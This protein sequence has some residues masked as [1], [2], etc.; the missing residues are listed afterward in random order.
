MRLHWWMA[1]AVVAAACA[2]AAS[3]TFNKD[4][5]PIL[6]K[7]CASCHRPGEVAPFSL[8]TYSDAKRYAPTIAD[9]TSKHIMPP[10]KASPGFGEF[11]D[12][13]A[14]SAEQ[15]ATISAWAKN[16]APEGDTKD[17]PAA[18]KF[19]DGWAL[20]PPDMIVEMPDTYQVP[21]DGY[22]IYKCFVIRTDFPEDT[23]IASVEV[24]PGNRRVLH[25]TVIYTDPAHAARA[26]AGDS[27]SYTCYGGPGITAIQ[28]DLMAGWAPG[29]NVKRMPDG[30]AFVAPKGSDLIVQNHY[31]PSG[32]PESDKTTIGI[33]FQKTP[34]VK[35]IFGI[36]M[37]QPN[38]R[39]PAG[40][41][42]QRVTATFTTPIELELSGIAPHMHLLGREMK[43]TA[44]LPDGDVKPLIWIKDWDFNWQLG[45]EFK[46]SLALPA[47]T[48]FDL[49]AFYDNSA[50]NPKNPSNPPKAVAWGEATTDEMCAAMLICVS[51]RASDRLTS[52]MSLAQQLL[53]GPAGRRFR[54]G[55]PDKNPN[56]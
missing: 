13:R 35:R 54:S 39:I 56:H 44:T 23:P 40:E 33:Y 29:M 43:I 27:G 36:P 37:V 34:V 53:A 55:A 10:W 30:V 5:A 41:S 4:I 52:W 2:N 14:L 7:N 50:A 28:T 16:G 1:F 8:L 12:V 9:A 17:L 32:R 45:Y 42:H 18:P 20:G 25:H 24:R 6:Y 48:R 3:P 15:I 19:T 46:E 49:E 26:R 47:Q 11:A 31:H 21:A 38:L 51:P 22:D